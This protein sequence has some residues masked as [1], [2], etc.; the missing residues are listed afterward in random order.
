MVGAYGCVIECGGALRRFSDAFAGETECPT[1][2]EVRGAVAGLNQALKHFPLCSS[3][4]VY[5][6]SKPAMRMLTMES[7]FWTRDK[8]KANVLTFNAL[9]DG[10]DVSFTHVRSH[11]GSLSHDTRRNEECD[12]ASKEARRKAE[13]RRGVGRTDARCFEG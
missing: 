10:R 13:T 11:Q 8:Y 5:M 7:W 4:E 3:V 12:R 9:L 1:Q 2:A 6:D